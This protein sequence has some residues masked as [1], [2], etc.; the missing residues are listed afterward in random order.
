[1]HARLETLEATLSEALSSALGPGNVVLVQ[2]DADIIERQR[3]LCA[4]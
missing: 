4:L 2:L 3:L 1:M